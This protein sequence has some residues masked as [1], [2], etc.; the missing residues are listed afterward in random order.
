MLMPEVVD[1]DLDDSIS[2]GR[3]GELDGAI[4]RSCPAR[5]PVRSPVL[6]GEARIEE[7]RPERVELA[8]VVPW[9][10]ARLIYGRAWPGSVEMTG[11]RV[12]LRRHAAVVAAL[13]G[14]SGRT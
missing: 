6:A 14:H 8:H 9:L 1:A 4:P 13:V 10:L 7:L 11:G 12:C 5:L 2:G 3:I